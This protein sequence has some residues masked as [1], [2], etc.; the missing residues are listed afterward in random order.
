M[1]FFRAF[2]SIPQTKPRGSKAVKNLVTLE[3]HPQL[4]FGKVNGWMFTSKKRVKKRIEKNQTQ[5]PRPLGPYSFAQLR[6]DMVDDFKEKGAVGALKA[7]HVLKTPEFWY[8]CAKT[9]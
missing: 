8:V 9:G 3:S 4:S 6:G 2:C 7:P 1:N 5:K